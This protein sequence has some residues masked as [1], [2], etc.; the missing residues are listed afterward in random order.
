M[1]TIMRRAPRA[2]RA[3]GLVRAA[4][5]LVAAAAVLSGA[6]AGCSSRG[7]TPPEVA[8]TSVNPVA[9][10]PT[11]RAGSVAPSTFVSLR[12]NPDTSDAVLAV[13]DAR[14]GHIVRRLHPLPWDGMNLAGTAIDRQGRIWVTLNRGP[15]CT[16]DTAGCGPKPHSCAS[17]VV[18]IDPHSGTARTVMSG[19]DD[20]LVSDAQPSPDGRRLA[21][22]HSGCA[23][24]YLTNA[25]LVRPLDG[26]RTVA[27]GASLPPCHE[28]ADPRWTGDGEHLS[29]VYGAAPGPGRATD[30]FGGCSAPAPAGLVV[31]D[32]ERT[33][34]GV[35]GPT[36]AADPNCPVDA[37]VPTAAGFAAIEQCGFGAPQVADQGVLLVGLGPGLARV[38]TT[39]IGTCGDGADLAVDGPGQHV[40]ISSYQFCPGSAV[41][42]TTILSTVTSAEPIA[43]PTGITR[44]IGGG[45][46]FAHPSW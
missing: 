19:G 37:V 7:R 12:A 3:P 34:P 17:R 1:M 36:A 27:I 9:A 16:N 11:T 24:S 42:P 31:V 44:E 23:R 28:L 25:L 35:D 18:V 38:S 29:V 21:Y 5:A 26:G 4:V 22:L 41:S 2:P 30:G 8:P 14:T 32:A 10:L 6:A 39:P 33:Q 46:P 45:D 20:E 13:S 43:G 15:T 40:L